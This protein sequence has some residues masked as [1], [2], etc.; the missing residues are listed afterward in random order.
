MFLRYK[1]LIKSYSRK[2]AGK[3][4]IR[5]DSVERFDN[6]NLELKQVSKKKNIKT[7]V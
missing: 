1:F 6:Q 2:E 4:F 7:N 5:S 3:S